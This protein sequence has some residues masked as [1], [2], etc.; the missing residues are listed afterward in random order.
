M[1]HVLLLLTIVAAWVVLEFRGIFSPGLLDDV[2]ALYTECAREMLVRHDY[3]TPFIDGIR[4]FDKPPLMYW[5]AAGSMRLFG[6]N[7]WAARLPLALLTLALLLAVCALG[8]RLFNRRGGLYAGLVTVTCIGPY[9]FTRFV[10]PDMLLALWMTL[11][12]HLLVEA[13]GLLGQA[14]VP[15]R[16]LRWVCWGFAA[17]AALNVLTKGL[18]GLVFPLGLVLLYLLATRQLPLLRRMYVGTSTLVFLLLAAPWHVLAAVRN[19]AV[20]GSAVARGW[21]WFFFVNEQFLRFLGKRIPHDYGQLP[22]PLFLGLGILW[23][24]PWA[25]FLP[26]AIAGA[27]KKL[28]AGAGRERD[29]ALLLLLWAGL[30]F[31]FFCFSSRQE[32]YSLPAL[33]ALALLAGGLLARAHDDRA[34]RR[35]VL[36]AGRWVVLPVSLVV[37]GL[38][39][40]FALTAPTPPPGMDI[41]ALLS[42]NPASYTLSLGHVL[43]LTGRAMGAFRL[44]L[45]ALCIAMLA[46]VLPSHLLRVR[47]RHL[48]A[49]L[50]LAVAGVAVLLCVHEGLVRFYPILGSKPLALAINAQLRPGD[51]VL[52]DGEYT[53]GSSI[54]FYTQQPVLLVNG[55]MN[56]TWYGSYWPDAPHIFRTDSELR[57]MWAAGTH[58]LFLLTYDPKRVEDLARYGAV[59]TVA[60][61]G[62]KTVLSN[63]ARACGMVVGE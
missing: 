48:A 31:G 10:I 59:V 27:F 49:N 37:A 19:P 58:R 61:S 32:Y 62:G 54:N 44:P 1:E 6:I 47:G 25:S 29:S 13:V 63:C 43:D 22:I 11:G 60:A 35:Q 18:I 2:D 17:V 53:L 8:T 12:A 16:R 39:G 23:L 20:A 55:R 15:E 5:M 40:Y 51:E 41:A 38:T 57:Q 3:V 45:A 24:A 14:V 42:S 34:A 46:G 50:L 4:F 26:A 28:R 30:V 9:L 21:L 56:G 7:D 52:I 36:L 33:P